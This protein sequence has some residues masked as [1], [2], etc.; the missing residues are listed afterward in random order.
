[1][2]R[3]L[4]TVCPDLTSL[5]RSSLQ[6]RKAHFLS[7]EKHCLSSSPKNKMMK[8]VSMLLVLMCQAVAFAPASTRTA[9]LLSLETS[10]GA[11]DPSKGLHAALNYEHE[12]TASFDPLCTSSTRH[13][14]AASAGL[15][16]SLL[17]FVGPV[18]AEVD[19]DDVEISE[20]PPVW[21]PII[22]A[23]AILGGVGLL[24][25]SLGDVISDEASL[26]L[27]SGAQAK[28]EMERSRSSY[29][30]KK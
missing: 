13:G 14:A 19:M 30:K 8:V 15:S 22:F 26:G 21:V 23:I 1:M 20:L 18:L 9:R 29:F 10:L 28:K 17:T 4:Q 11:A 16:T 2:H 3:Q 5:Q 25:G 27:M 7:T 12:V 24:T 6:L